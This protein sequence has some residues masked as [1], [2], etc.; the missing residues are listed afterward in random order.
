MLVLWILR[1]LHPNLSHSSTTP[2]GKYSSTLAR[3]TPRSLPQQNRIMTSRNRELLAI[4]LTLEEWHHWLEGAQHR[5]T[6]IT[7]HKNLQYTQNAKRL[8]SCQGRWILYFT[9]FNFTITYRPGNN[10][11]KADSLSHIH[12]PDSPSAPKPI[13]P[14]AII[15]SPIQWE[16]DEQ[17]CIATLTEPAP[18]GG[19]EGKT[20]TPASI[21]LT[22]LG[23]HHA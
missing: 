6:V 18:L 8:N 15:V 21:R 14:P 23:S 10:N 17:I 4:K 19:P 13:L 3:S 11:V 5:F 12:Q 1:S 22:L 7:D 16:L 20:Y 9:R 2:C